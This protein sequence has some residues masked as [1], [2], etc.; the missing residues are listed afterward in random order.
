MT[1]TEQLAREAESSRAQLAASLAEL[2]GRLSPQGLRREAG[3]AVGNF[4]PARFAAGLK[5]DVTNSAVPVAMLAAGVLWAMWNQRGDRRSSAPPGSV[6]SLVKVGDALVSAA[7]G[8]IHSVGAAASDARAKGEAVVASVRPAVEA[9]ARASGAAR[10]EGLAAGSRAA[11]G[12]RSAMDA[13]RSKSAA[14]LEASIHVTERASRAVGAA[15]NIASRDPV[16]I[17]GV[18]LA[19]AGIATTVFGV[20]RHREKTTATRELVD[21][22][23]A[24]AGTAS[25]QAPEQA[26]STFHHELPGVSELGRPE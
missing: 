23:R 14:A 11:E 12:A 24:E 8:L 6:A 7:A 16:F 4:G 19:A 22:A 1:S 25:P 5:E 26:A 2:R 10:E 15:A 13:A 21:H 9:A 3:R 20:S 18:G 17:A